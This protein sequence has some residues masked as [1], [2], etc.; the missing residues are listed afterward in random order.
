M[1]Q[2]IQHSTWLNPSKQALATYLFLLILIIIFKLLAFANISPFS[3]RLPWII[4]GS[5]LLLFGIFNSLFSVAAPVY[6]KYWSRSIFSYMALAIISALTAYFFSGIS[7][8]DAGSFRW[9]YIVLT[10]SYLI[11]LSI[12]GFIKVIVEIAQRKDTRN[13]EN[14]RYRKP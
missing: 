3:E 5:F 9:I 4:S 10:F 11:F 12:V 7:I 6:N 13:F 14:R 1:E 2:S 8:N